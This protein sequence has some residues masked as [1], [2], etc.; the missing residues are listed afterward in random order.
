MVSILINIESKLGARQM[1]KRKSRRDGAIKVGKKWL[2]ALHNFPAI[3]AALSVQ[4]R[5]R[6]QINL[7]Q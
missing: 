2:V 1:V 7:S 5:R 4:Y 6:N 3:L